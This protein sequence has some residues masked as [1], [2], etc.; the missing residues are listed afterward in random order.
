MRLLLYLIARRHEPSARPAAP[1]RKA[2]LRGSSRAHT[3]ARAPTE[4]RKANKLKYVSHNALYSN[5]LKYVSHNAL[6]SLGV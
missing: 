1:L 2:S 5:K 4:L 3:G 6:Y